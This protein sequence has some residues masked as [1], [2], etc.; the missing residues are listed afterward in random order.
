MHAPRPWTFSGGYAALSTKKD[1]LSCRR[2][3]TSIGLKKP[4][5]Q[6]CPRSIGLKETERAGMPALHRVERCA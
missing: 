6:G 1:I 3:A 5:G 4:S 2:D